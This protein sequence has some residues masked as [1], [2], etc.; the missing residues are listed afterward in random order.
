MRITINVDD[1]IF[2]QIIELTQARTRTKAVDKALR[3]YIYI[4]RKEQLLELSG[5]LHIMDHS[6]KLRELEKKGR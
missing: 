4:K 6:R 2:D 3:E 1:S 5:K